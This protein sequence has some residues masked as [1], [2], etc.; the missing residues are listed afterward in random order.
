MRLFTEALGLMQFEQF[1]LDVG[2]YETR[3]QFKAIRPPVEDV[4][5]PSLSVD[6]I[7]S[8]KQFEERLPALDRIV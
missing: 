4:V 6:R 8:R 2:G 7:V 5:M 1:G 3:D